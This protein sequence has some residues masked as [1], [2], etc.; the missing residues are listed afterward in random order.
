ML[1][2]FISI[3]NPNV[4]CII[5]KSIV[6]GLDNPKLWLYPNH[7]NDGISAANLPNNPPIT[8]P[9]NKNTTNI[10]IFLF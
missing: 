6:N 8:N 9:A 10:H 2:T 7:H 3:I 1:A 5:P 4:N